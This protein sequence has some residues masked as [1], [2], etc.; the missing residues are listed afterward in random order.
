[1]EYDYI[2]CGGGSAGCV[3]AHRLSSRSANKVL[4][5]EAGMDTPPEKVPEEILDSYPI[6]AYFNPK[7]QWTKLRVHLQPVS[8]NAPPTPAVR[9]YEQARIMGGGSS[10]N[11]QLA[12]RGAPG[13]YDEWQEMGADGW[14]WERVLPFFKKVER[15]VDFDGPFHG[16]NGAIPVRR[17]FPDSWPGFARAVGQALSDK[18][19]VYREDQNAEFEDGHFPITFS[20][21]YDRRVSAAI[22]Y[23]TPVVRQRENL[24]IIDRTQVQDIVFEGTQAVGVNIVRNGKAETVRGREII[25]CAGAIHSPALLMRSGVGPAGHLRDLGIG[26]V[27]DVPAIGQNLGE[28][29]S[30]AVAAYIDLA[31]RLPKTM[32]RH[33]H[34]AFRYSSG[35]HEA[36]QGDMFCSVMGKSAWHPVGERLGGCLLWVNKSYSRGQVTLTSSDWQAEPNVEFNLCQ[37]IRDLDRLK[38]GMRLLAELYDNPAMKAIA[39]HPFPSSYSER[40]RNV[41]VINTKNLILT[42]ILATMMDGP[43]WFRRS[44]IKNVVTEGDD[45]K[46]LLADESAM[47]DY[48]RRTVTGTWHASCTARMGPANDPSAATD[49]QGRVK[50]VAGLRVVDASL[51]PTTPRANTNFPT[52]MLAEKIADAMGAG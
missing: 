5:I 50:G 36:P 42:S 31:A 35:M 21:L 51:M 38:Q 41:G 20:N 3:L 2:I 25:S 26:V 6:V 27:A 23:L 8:H 4:L 40:V 30:I 24:T 18:G 47:E 45:L 7:Y 11:A 10:I 46:T 1:M 16:K 43:S 44:L 9:R 48:I 14:G 28:H 39:P 29:P 33:L 32:R 22:A 15:D 12:N 13:D 37:D 34:V 19:L 17:M 49:S 52:L